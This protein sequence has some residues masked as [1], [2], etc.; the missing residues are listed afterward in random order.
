MH[1]L[2]GEAGGVAAVGVLGDLEPE[3]EESIDDFVVDSFFRG[4]AWGGG[5]D[6]AW[7]GGASTLS[8]DISAICM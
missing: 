8:D 1:T 4:C 2:F 6:C 5:G 3:D 7:G